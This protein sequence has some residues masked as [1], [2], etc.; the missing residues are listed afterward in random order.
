VA[1]PWSAVVPQGST[2]GHPPLP[3]SSPAKS[4]S[5]PPPL[6]RPRVARPLWAVSGGSKCTLGCGPAPRH[7]SATSPPPAPPP[8]S[9]IGSASS[10]SALPLRTEKGKRV[11]NVNRNFY[12]VL[13]AN[14]VTQMNS[15]HCTAGSFSLIGGP[16]C[17]MR[18]RVRASLL[19]A[20]PRLVLGLWA[21]G[22][23]GLPTAFSFS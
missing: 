11:R 22:P 5:A 19:C 9:R 7:T 4:T 12:K 3:W 17:K 10:A 14:F 16:L 18:I 21:A 20:R 1:T 8:A 15:T 13:N 6:L 23:N 2:A